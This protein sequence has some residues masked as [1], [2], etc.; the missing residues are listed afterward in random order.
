MDECSDPDR[1]WYPYRRVCYASMERAG[2]EAA[3]E[4]RHE[5]RPYHDGSFT[6]W[7]EKRSREFPYRY[8]EGVTV[9]AAEV[10]LTPWDEFTTKTKASP[11][12][13]TQAEEPT[14][15]EAPDQ[16]DQR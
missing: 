4:A 11:V 1:V 15:Q 13:P 2:A 12:P 3:Y 9:G 6:R 16:A 10:D 8:N 5:K 14:P 7:G